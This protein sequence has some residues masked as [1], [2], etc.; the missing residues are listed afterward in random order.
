MNSHRIGDLDDVRVV[1]RIV[2]DPRGQD[3]A[4]A[5]IVVREGGETG[6]WFFVV[7]S[8]FGFPGLPRVFGMGEKSQGE[9]PL[10]VEVDGGCEP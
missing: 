2:N 4:E 8:Y 7:C 9:D 3:G 10:L 1:G 6:G 5:G